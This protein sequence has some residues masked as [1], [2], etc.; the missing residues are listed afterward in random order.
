MKAYKGFKG[1]VKAISEIKNEAD[2]NVV[3]GEIDDSF[4]HGKVTPTDI[5]TLYKIINMIEIKEK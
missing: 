1:L 3:C 4:T 2:M 5:A